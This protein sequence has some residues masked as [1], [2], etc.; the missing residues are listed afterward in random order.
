[1][2]AMDL[3][4]FMVGARIGYEN[5]GASFYEIVDLVSDAVDRGEF[6]VIGRDGE[7][8]YS[9]EIRAGESFT[10]EPGDLGSGGAPIPGKGYG[11]MVGLFQSFVE[12]D[13]VP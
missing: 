6:L 8:Y 12:G 1:M 9:D 11:T 2:E 3:Y 5:P 10:G 4:N 7:L 13:Y